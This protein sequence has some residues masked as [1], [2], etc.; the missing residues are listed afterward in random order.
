MQTGQPR[1][2]VALCLQNPDAVGATPGRTAWRGES[3]RVNVRPAR[4]AS[5]AGLARAHSGFKSQRRTRLPGAWP[6]GRAERFPAAAVRAGNAPRTFSGQEAW[7]QAGPAGQPSHGRDPHPAHQPSPA[8]RV[9]MC[10]PR[11]PSQPGLPA[12]PVYRPPHN[13]KTSRCFCCA[14]PG[15]RRAGADARAISAAACGARDNRRDAGRLPGRRGSLQVEHSD[16]TAADARGVVLRPDDQRVSDAHGDGPHGARDRN[17][18]HE[19][20]HPGQQ[21]VR[22]G[23]LGL[24]GR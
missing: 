5:R 19:A 6:F 9:S 15:C 22:P 8:R 20:R 21:Q 24:P 16:A 4:L 7:R 18:R 17:R 14:R 1:Q 10:P 12:C 11:P 2:A 3:T 23:D 13:G